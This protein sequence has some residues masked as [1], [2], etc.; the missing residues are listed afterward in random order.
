MNCPKTEI[1]DDL[2]RFSESPLLVSSVPQV[3][4]KKE[5]SRCVSPPP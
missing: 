5:S 4:A 2:A 3:R 1:I